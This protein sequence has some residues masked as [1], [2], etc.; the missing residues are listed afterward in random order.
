MGKVKEKAR[1]WLIRH[2]SDYNEK[3]YLEAEKRLKYMKKRYIMLDKS[4]KT[5]I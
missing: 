4:N 1:V 2:L 3:G 5:I